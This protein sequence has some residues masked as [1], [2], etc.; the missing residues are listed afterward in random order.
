MID[1][2]IY[3][4]ELEALPGILEQAGFPASRRC[5]RPTRD[6]DHLLGRL[7]FPGCRA[8][9]RGDDRARASQ[10]EPGAAQRKL[11][12]F[13][14]EQY[15]DGRPPLSLGQV[16]SLPVPGQAVARPR[17]EL[18]LHPA[19]GH[20]VDGTA[21]C[22]CPGWACLICG[23]YLSPVEI[24]W[25]SAGGSLNGYRAT[26]ERLR[27]LVDAGGHGCPWPRRDRCRA[28]E[29]LRILDQDLAYLER[30]RQRRPRCH[31]AARES[32]A[33]LNGRS[34]PRT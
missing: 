14:D 7:A 29:A 20:T 9:L 12:D 21:F 28:S 17:H 34:T 33:R 10:A 32:T 1:S 27:P 19:D 2:P 24:P 11:R 31:P 25:I 16:Q 13:D 23:D 15:V 30:P 18:E 26:L 3:P 4:E 6:W 8:R 22:I 5:S